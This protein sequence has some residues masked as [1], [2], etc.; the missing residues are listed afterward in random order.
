MP[1]RRAI[2][3]SF[4][5]GTLVFPTVAGA[6]GAPLLSDP[7]A[8]SA[9]STPAPAF[10]PGRVIVE[11]A[12][13]TERAEKTG[14]REEAEVTFESNL[15]AP[16]F[17][18][19]K[20]EAGQSVGEAI[21]E[22]EGESAVLVA[23]RDAMDHPLAVPNDPLFDEQW[24]LQNIG[25]TINEET[26]VP[27]D[28]IDVV[29]AWDRTVGSP[30]IVVADIDN[31]Y[32][33]NSPDLSTRVWTNPGEIAGNGIDDDDN[34]YV[35][36]IHGWDFVGPNLNA[37]TEDAD[38]SEE[39]PSTAG[40]G[41]HTAGIIGA[42]GNNG[43]GIT[44]VAQNVR[45]M[46]L[47]VCSTAPGGTESSC[48]TSSIIAAINYAG[49]N[50]A[51]VANI[52]LG[53]SGVSVAE[54]DAFADN[55]GTLY[56][57][58][59]GN[60]TADNDLVPEHPCDDEP[61]VSGV[62][63]AIENIVCVA[64]TGQFDQLAS[65]SDYGPKSVDLGAPGKQILSVLPARETIFTDNFEANDFDSRWEKGGGEGAAFERTDEAPL[66]SFGMTDSPGRGP[67]PNSLVGS[68]VAGPLTVPAG[69]GKC[70]VTMDASVKTGGGIPGFFLR[71]AGAPEDGIELPE[72]AGP[73]MQHFSFGPLD[74]EFAGSNVEL[75][76]VYWAGASPSADSGLWVDDVEVSCTAP[77][78]TPPTWGYMEGTS[79]AAPMVSGAAALLYSLKPSATVEEVEYALF[80]GVDPDPELAGKTVTGGR[81][82]V[83]ASMDWLE[84][85]A[86]V[87][88]TSPA[89][90][91]ADA[92]PRIVGSVKAGTRV[93]IFAGAGCGG[94][95]IATGSP[96]ELESPGLA[97]S[98]PNGTTEQFS[99]LV[100]TRYTTSSCSTPVSFT[101]S[102]PS[103][104]PPTIT[105]P[106][107]ESHPSESASP[108]PS[109]APQPA[110]ICKV[111]KLD[112]KSLA[113]AKTILKHAGCTL[114]KVTDPK[115]PAKRKKGA[116][117][118]AASKPAAGAKSANPI[119]LRL[120]LP[121]PKHHR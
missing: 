1:G 15:G 14:V 16:A 46:P 102:A 91:A 114:G 61:G 47:R 94:A 105:V 53:G 25:A 76:F 55:P 54:V 97:V 98:V 87:I 29:P 13:G 118:V 83:D 116:L 31:G 18:L 64:A 96:T 2:L 36:D 81:L 66:T 21:D 5:L 67:V 12:P 6:T 50:G 100:E 109:P 103:T 69:D 4:I 20:V 85:P 57:I 95:A 52:S 71:K 22:L 28:D 84:P 19:V 88:S 48:P 45:I 17:Q 72:T 79:M 73:G 93:K 51:R 112:G 49:R 111:P 11:W 107:V 38:P 68:R 60:N 37:P 3:L 90:P 56:V 27:G 110:P 40:H 7:S 24:A 74:T 80:E 106:L 41:I 26:G 78:S 23:E 43:V 39:D 8:P 34:G 35:D 82:D 9:P 44:G 120:T 32:A 33:F 10:V 89:S 113:E 59:A 65:F 86:P 99:A 101:N 108:S 75:E 121:R 62:P 58:A 77:L 117:V 70:S 63:G 104:A 92:A 119:S 30:N 115:G 42:A